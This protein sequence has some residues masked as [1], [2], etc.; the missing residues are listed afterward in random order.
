MVWNAPTTC[1]TFRHGLPLYKR[2]AL[3]R[4]C[5]LPEYHIGLLLMRALFTSNVIP[6]QELQTSQVESEAGADLRPIMKHT[7][8]HALRQP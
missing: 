7:L 8:R 2:D 5:R 1:E 3:T 6:A 4:I